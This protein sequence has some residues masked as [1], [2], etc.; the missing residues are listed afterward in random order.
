MVTPSEHSFKFRTKWK[1]QCIGIISINHL[2]ISCKVVHPKVQFIIIIIICNEPLWLAHQR[3]K[4]SKICTLPQKFSQNRRTFV[5]TPPPRLL[6]PFLGGILLKMWDQMNS[7]TFNNLSP[8]GHTQ[9]GS[10]LST[11]ELGPVS[12][13]N[14]W[15][16][17]HSTWW[18]CI[19]WGPILERKAW[20]GFPFVFES[21]SLHA[22]RSIWPKHLVVKRTVHIQKVLRCKKTLTYMLYAKEGLLEQTRK[23][24]VCPT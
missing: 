5:H 18:K 15:E 22:R 8:K 12:P 9:Q 11:M 23:M 3:K 14:M 17:C 21:T 2:L 10:F 24:A 4:K 1:H 7:T 20:Q 16:R 13:R 19:V 6:A